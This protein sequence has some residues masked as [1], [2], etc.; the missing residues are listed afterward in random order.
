MSMVTTRKSWKSNV[1]HLLSTCHTNIR[2][3]IKFLVSDCWLPYFWTLPCKF[4]IDTVSGE[5][6]LSKWKTSSKSLLKTERPKKQRANQFNSVSGAMPYQ[7][8]WYLSLRQ[9]PTGYDWDKRSLYLYF[10]CTIKINHLKFKEYYNYHLKKSKQMKPQKS[11]NSES[12]FT[13]L[14]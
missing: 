3:R 13:D 2:V 10:N 4:G 8:H 12:H 5:W 7:E 9:S 6:N 14:Y 1:Y 11:Y